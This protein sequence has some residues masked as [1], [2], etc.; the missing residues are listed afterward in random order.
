MENTVMKL[1]CSSDEYEEKV[2]GVALPSQIG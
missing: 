2:N 1:Y